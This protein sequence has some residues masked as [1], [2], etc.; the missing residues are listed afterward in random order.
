MAPSRL[1]FLVLLVSMLVFGIDG[2]ASSGKKA[3]VQIEIARLPE[4]L[5]GIR[6]CRTTEFS[7]KK[8]LTPWDLKFINA[9]SVAEGKVTCL[10]AKDTRTKKIIGT[11][12]CRKSNKDYVYVMNVQVNPEERG[13]GIGKLLILD[14]VEKFATSNQKSK[15]QLDVYTENS[16]ALNM[17]LKYG[18]SPLNILHAGMLSIANVFGANLEV[19]MTKDIVQN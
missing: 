2:F 12:D 10:V 11:A 18:Y 15:V 9:T 16:V 14:G 1:I 13:K 5:E 4:D 6:E 17:Y 19:T 8:Y 7:D 3:P